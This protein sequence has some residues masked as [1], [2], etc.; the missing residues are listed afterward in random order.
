MCNLSND[1]ISDDEWKRIDIQC[2]RQKHICKKKKSF[3]PK[4][5]FIK[6]IIKKDEDTLTKLNISFDQLKKFFIKLRSLYSIHKSISTVDIE[7]IGYFDNFKKINIS[8]W[9]CK[10][11]T[12]AYFTLDDCDYE[13]YRFS[14]KGKEFCPFHSLDNK[15]NLYSGSQDWL[16]HNITK[17]EYLHMGDL[18]FHQIIDHHFFQSK[19]SNYRVDPIKLVKVF[20]LKQEQQNTQTVL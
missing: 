12:S 18:L 4:D 17:N 6:D 7:F 1:L 19:N 11:I 14:W 2:K 16:I 13:I 8:N 9:S 10:N 5:E 3:F 15:D 20:N